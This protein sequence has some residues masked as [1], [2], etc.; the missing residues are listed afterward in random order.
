MLNQLGQFLVTYNLDIVTV[1]PNLADRVVFLETFLFIVFKP[2]VGTNKEQ[3]VFC[4][5]EL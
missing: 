2:V 3:S 4:N 5:F 1:L